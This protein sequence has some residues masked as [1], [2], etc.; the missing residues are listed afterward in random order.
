VREGTRHAACTDL[1]NVPTDHARFIMMNESLA[2]Y[3]NDHLAGS[4]VALEFLD[5][6]DA[7]DGALR[8]Q[9]GP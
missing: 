8:R 7:G 2:T 1:Y 6:L 4:V 5:R 9:A 3:L